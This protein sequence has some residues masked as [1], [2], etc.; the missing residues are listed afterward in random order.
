M[1][2]EWIFVALIALVVIG[3]SQIPK[4]ARNLGRAQNEFK[5]GL[6]EGKSDVDSDA[7][8]SKA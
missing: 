7:D 6:E 8:D 3:G 2:N 1:G 5:R 4:L